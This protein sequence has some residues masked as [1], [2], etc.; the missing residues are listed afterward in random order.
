MVT[1]IEYLL[2]TDKTFGSM[3][4]IAWGLWEVGGKRK[5]VTGVDVLQS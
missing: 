1:V 5:R 2:S 3:P 4:S